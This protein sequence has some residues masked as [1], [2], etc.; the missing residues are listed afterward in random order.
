MSEDNGLGLASAAFIDL[1]LGKA[2]KKDK[3]VRAFNFI[4]GLIF[5]GLI[6][7]LVFVTIKFS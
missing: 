6:C 4:G 7:L 3:W 5:I 2:A 1:L